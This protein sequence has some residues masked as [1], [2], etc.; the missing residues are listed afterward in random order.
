[1]N[2]TCVTCRIGK[3]SPLRLKPGVNMPERLLKS[4]Q[5]SN[6]VLKLTRLMEEKAKIRQVG[7]EVVVEEFEKLSRRRISEFA[8]M[9]V[10]K[11][12]AIFKEE[13]GNETFD[14]IKDNPQLMSII[15]NYWRDKI[16]NLITGIANDIVEYFADVE[17]V[18]VSEMK[19]GLML[20]IDSLK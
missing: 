14:S 20:G 6:F 5:A 17:E 19:K 13:I 7:M 15:D 12:I 16:L 2:W 9:N 18:E 3:E 4:L 11:K 10:A 1:M 8:D